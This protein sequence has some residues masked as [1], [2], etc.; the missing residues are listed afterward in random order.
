MCANVLK[1]WPARAGL[2]R[3]IGR[4]RARDSRQLPS[5]VILRDG[6]LNLTPAKGA[7]L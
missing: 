3:V 7:F 5:G 4:L 1:Q 2:V 6:R